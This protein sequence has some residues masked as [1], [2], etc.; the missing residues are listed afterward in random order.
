MTVPPFYLN[1]VAPLVFAPVRLAAPLPLVL[2]RWYTL[3]G[4]GPP[5]FSEPQRKS[6]IVTATLR[7]QLGHLLLKGGVYQEEGGIC[8]ERGVLTHQLI[9]IRVS[10]VSP[11]K[12]GISHRLCGCP[13]AD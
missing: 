10:L 8:I 2:S 1:P 5:S 9:N 7:Y 6:E 12:Q 4:R 13:I 11:L 3:L